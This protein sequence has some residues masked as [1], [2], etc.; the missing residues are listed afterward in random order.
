MLRSRNSDEI[1]LFR[2]EPLETE[3]DRQWTVDLLGFYQPYDT[4]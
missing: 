2:M 4:P 1:E 3:E